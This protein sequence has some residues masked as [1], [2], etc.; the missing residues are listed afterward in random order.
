MVKSKESLEEILMRAHW[1]HVKIGEKLE[2]G[3]PGFKRLHHYAKRLSDLG[4]PGSEV[5]SMFADLYWDAFDELKKV[6]KDEAAKD[7]SSKEPYFD[8]H[9]IR[10]RLDE[11][12]ITEEELVR[13]FEFC[14]NL[15]IQD[16]MIWWTHSE[17][18]NGGRLDNFLNSLRIDK[19]YA[20]G[21][22]KKQKG[23]PPEKLAKLHAVGVYKLKSR[24]KLLSSKAASGR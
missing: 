10:F 3:S 16:E 4:M 6:P 11:T 7:V 15:V 18:A 2:K 14:G 22:T 19:A 12:E 21:P 9:G 24:T 17:G 1:P 5:A 13:D 8:R 20:F 23:W